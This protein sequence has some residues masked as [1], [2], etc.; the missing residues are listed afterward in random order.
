MHLL[1]SKYGAAAAKAF[2]LLVL[3][4]LANEIWSNTKVMSL[5]FGPEGSLPYWLAVTLVTAFTVA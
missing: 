1:V 3:F 2:M 5:Y 4:R